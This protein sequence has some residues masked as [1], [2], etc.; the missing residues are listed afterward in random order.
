MTYLLLALWLLGGLMTQRGHLRQ[1]YRNATPDI[2]KAEG[3]EH[4]PMFVLLLVLTL[5]ALFLWPVGVVYDY[6]Q[7]RKAKNAERQRA[8]RNR[9]ALR[10]PFRWK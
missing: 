7:E 10:K 4:L 5:V 8:E 1:L 3:A 6:L 9:Q 2:R